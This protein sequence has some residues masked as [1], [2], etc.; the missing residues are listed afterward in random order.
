MKIYSENAE[1]AA[2]E[3]LILRA[4]ASARPVPGMPGAAAGEQ[5]REA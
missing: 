2:R 4:E 5:K 3:F 1:A